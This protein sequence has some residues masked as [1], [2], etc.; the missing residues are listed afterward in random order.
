[1]INN[2]TFKKNI[3]IFLPRKDREDCSPT[4]TLDIY[5]RTSIRYNLKSYSP[6]FSI[7]KYDPH[8]ISITHSCII[9]FFQLKYIGV[10]TLR[11][12][13]LANIA[14][15]NSNI[16]IM[17]A[18]PNPE[19]SASP[20]IIAPNWID[21]ITAGFIQCLVWAILSYFDFTSGRS[22]RKLLS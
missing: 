15:I 22:S 14:P 17:K 8:Q 1:M 4:S 11:N 12:T 2:S 5:A 18:A 13:T 7:S 16:I 10:Y 21:V 9:L 3:L 19:P 6:I 20:F